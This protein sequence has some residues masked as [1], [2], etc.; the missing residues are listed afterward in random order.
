[1]KGVM[2]NVCC[3]WQFDFESNHHHNNIYDDDDD[4]EGVMFTVL[5][6][7]L[8]TLRITIIAEIIF[9]TEYITFYIMIVL[10]Q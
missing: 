8:S 9:L 6:Q 3:F 10:K 5:W 4:D 1:M 2:I 7:K